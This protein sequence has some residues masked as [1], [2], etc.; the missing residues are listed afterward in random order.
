MGFTN[1]D[2]V[3][4]E[5]GGDRDDK[6][7]VEKETSS[8]SSDTE[9]E[10]VIN[11]VIQDQVGPG[12]ATNFHQCE[13]KRSNTYQYEDYRNV[14]TNARLRKTGKE[15]ITERKQQHKV[16]TKGKEEATRVD[17]GYKRPALKDKEG[18]KKREEKELKYEVGINQVQPARYQTPHHNQERR[19]THLRKQ[20][21]EGPAQDL[22]SH[23]P[24][25]NA[26]RKAARM[27]A[28]VRG[29]RNKA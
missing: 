5:E 24:S 16:K 21:A 12:R 1:L 25:T 26:T 2:Q 28:R 14:S 6:G 13:T 19:A 20:E 9:E 15:V 3:D 4:Q 22:T 27:R 29:G 18:K 17:S 10:E 23:I 7:K 11:Q 8:K